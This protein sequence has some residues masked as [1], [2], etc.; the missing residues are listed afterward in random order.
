M[1]DETPI[2]WRDVKSFDDLIQPA[3]ETIIRE[4][5]KAADR[6]CPDLRRKGNC[7]YYCGLGIQ[8]VLEQTH[9]HIIQHTCVTKILQN[10][11]YGV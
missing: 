9:I 4:A 7:F 2:Q 1:A 8:R 3:A 11:N 10:Y 6:A 5:V